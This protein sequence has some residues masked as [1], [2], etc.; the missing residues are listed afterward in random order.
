LDGDQ[1]NCLKVCEAVQHRVASN[2]TPL[3]VVIRHDQ[4]PVGQSVVR[5]VFAHN[6]VKNTTGSF[7]EST[8]RWAV[9]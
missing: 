4:S 9:E 8:Y 5:R 6:G 7:G 3:H 1:S 2:A